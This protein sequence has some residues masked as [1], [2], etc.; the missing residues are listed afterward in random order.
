MHA[1]SAVDTPSGT[2]VQQLPPCRASDMRQS[3]DADV[4]ESARSRVSNP[5]GPAPGAA[6]PRWAEDMTAKTAAHCRACQQLL[7]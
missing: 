7:P 5:G 2:C 4:T 6:L 1:L 3:P